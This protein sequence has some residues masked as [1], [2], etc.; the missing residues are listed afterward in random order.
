M[1]MSCPTIIIVLFSFFVSSSVVVFCNFV[2]EK[3]WQK[4]SA[5]AFARRLKVLEIPLFFRMS[6]KCK[7]GEQE[8]K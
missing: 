7:K 5:T 3:D 6:N 1:Q 2:H 4:K 8:E